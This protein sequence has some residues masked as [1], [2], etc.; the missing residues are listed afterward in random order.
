MAK[1][2]LCG[3]EL[4]T[5]QGL[6]GHMTFAHG[7]LGGGTQPVARLAT[8]KQL[9]EL[10]YRL[11]QTESELKKTTE[12]YQQSAK[13][14]FALFELFFRRAEADPDPEHLKAVVE[15]V[16]ELIGLPDTLSVMLNEREIE[17]FSKFKGYKKVR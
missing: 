6:R 13:L 17:L 8:E 15:Y 9:G 11:E 5:T 12:R 3:K 4:R 1:C 16:T 10:E 2:D 14:A 7:A